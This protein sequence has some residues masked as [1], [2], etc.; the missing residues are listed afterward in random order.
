[1]SLKISTEEAKTFVCDYYSLKGIVS[2]PDD[3]ELTKKYRN[4]KGVTCRDFAN[5]K[6]R[7]RAIVLAEVSSGD[8]V[9]SLKVIENENYEFFLKMVTDLPLFY[10]VPVIC[11]DGL[12]FIFES[13]NHFEQLGRPSQHPEQHHLLLRKK[14]L[15]IFREEELFALGNNLRFSFPNLEIEDVVRRLEKS[16]VTF[17]PKL[18]DF[19]DDR[20]YQP[21]MPDVDLAAYLFPKDEKLNNDEA[22]ETIFSMISQKEEFTNEDYARIKFLLKKVKEQEFPTVRKIALGFKKKPDKKLLSIFDLE[23]NRKKAQKIVKDIWLEK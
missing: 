5:A 15:T 18:F 20:I 1:M 13:A 12:I 3:W 16:K 10:Y 7:V 2:N 14:L 22:I 11:N 8:I 23:A 19:L 6:N 17:N 21:I 9:P 4:F